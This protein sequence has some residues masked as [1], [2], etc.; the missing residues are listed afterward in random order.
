MKCPQ[1]GER[2]RPSSTDPAFWLCDPCDVTVAL[3]R[4]LGRG[5]T[6]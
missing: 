3:H 4:Y 5:V 1:C 2:M 6:T